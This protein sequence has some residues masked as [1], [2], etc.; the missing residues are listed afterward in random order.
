MGG[1][2]PSLVAPQISVK[3]QSSNKWVGF[4]LAANHKLSRYLLEFLPPSNLVAFLSILAK[5]VYTD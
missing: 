5:T 2:S 4:R 3:D 1:L